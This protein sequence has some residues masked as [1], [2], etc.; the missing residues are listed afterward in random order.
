MRFAL[1]GPY[2]LA[3]LWNFVILTGFWAVSTLAGAL[4]FRKMPA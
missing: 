2:R 4:L 3:P 1:G